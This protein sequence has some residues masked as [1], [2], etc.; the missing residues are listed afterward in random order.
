MIYWKV[1]ISDWYILII[2]MYCTLSFTV[3]LHELPTG[4]YTMNDEEEY[5]INGMLLFVKLLLTCLLIIVIF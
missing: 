1:R 4:Q 3:G 2:F 5:D